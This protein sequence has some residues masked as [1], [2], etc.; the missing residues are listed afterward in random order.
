VFGVSALEALFVALVAL[1][2]FGPARLAGAA[3]EWGTT[4]GKVRR[5]LSEA[6]AELVSEDYP[7]EWFED[8]GHQVG[9]LF[10]KG[11]GD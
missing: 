4:L 2:V 9:D 1:L 3:R 11:P 7:D 5:S 10:D 8:H 6:A